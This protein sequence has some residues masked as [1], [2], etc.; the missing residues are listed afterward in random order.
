MT[1][2]KTV[3]RENRISEPK[4]PV[5]SAVAEY[6]SSELP[7]ILTRTLKIFFLKTNTTEKDAIIHIK[8]FFLNLILH[9]GKKNKVMNPV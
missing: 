1:K 6:L 9:N 7:K 5:L 4:A 8:S 3:N 2:H